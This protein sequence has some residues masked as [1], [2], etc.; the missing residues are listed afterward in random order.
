MSKIN[1]SG[2]LQLTELNKPT[3]VGESITSLNEIYDIPNPYVG[4]RVYVEDE[5]KSYIIKSLKGKIINGILVS[6]AQVDSF[7]LEGEDLRELIQATQQQII[8][9]DNEDISVVNN[10]LKFK[11]RDSSAGLGYVILR[12]DKTFKEQVVAENT[13]Y[14]VRYN[15]NL[16]GEEITMPENSI[17]KFEGGSISNGVITSNIKVI[18]QHNIKCTVRGDIYDTN[19]N[20]VISSFVPSELTVVDSQEKF[21][22]IIEEVKNG[23]PVRAE[24]HKGTYYMSPT[25]FNADFELSGNDGVTIKQRNKRFRKSELVGIDGTHY[26]CSLSEPLSPFSLFVYK[27]RIVDVS[28]YTTQT[29]GVNNTDSEIIPLGEKEYVGVKKGDK[30]KLKAPAGFKIKEGQKI[31]G[32]YDSAWITSKF[33][34]DEMNGE[35]MICTQISNSSV[36]NPNLNITRY[37][38]GIDY[39]LFNTHLETN[40]IYYDESYV[41]IPL[42][43]EYVDV[44]ERKYENVYFP[45]SLI[46]SNKNIKFNN[47]TFADT[48]ALIYFEQQPDTK[49]E[50]HKC[51]VRRIA[52]IAINI[53]SCLEYD[54]PISIIDSCDF[55]DCAFFDNRI[56]RLLGWDSAGF[57]K[58]ADIEPRVKV[59]R[60]FFKQKDCVQYKHTAQAITV[61][62]N[63]EIVDC[64]MCNCT[65]GAMSLSYGNIIVKGC[66]IY[67]D[68]VFNANKRRNY[69][70]DF[71]AIYCN[72]IA[73][74]K[75]SEDSSY[76]YIKNNK[77]HTIL[78]EGC[79]IYG[80]TTAQSTDGHGIY[81]DVGRGDVTCKGNVISA[82]GLHA[83]DSR[84]VQENEGYNLPLSSIR[85]VIEGNVLM[86]PY[87]LVFGNEVDDENKTTPQN[88]YVLRGNTNIVPEKT[89]DIIVDGLEDAGK[90]IVSTSYGLLNKPQF[91][92]LKKVPWIIFKNGSK[93]AVEEE[94]FW[95]FPSEESKYLALTAT[96]PDN[97]RH[98][99]AIKIS[100]LQGIFYDINVE[101]GAT[102]Y[103]ESGPTRN[104]SINIDGGGM[105]LTAVRGQFDEECKSLNMEIYFFNFKGFYTGNIY[106]HISLPEDIDIKYELND[107]D[108]TSAKSVKTILVGNVDQAVFKNV[109]NDAFYNVIKKFYIYIPPTQY[110]YG[111]TR[112]VFSKFGLH[113]INGTSDERPKI[114]NKNTGLDGLVQGFEYFDTTLGKPIWWTGDKWVDSAGE[115]V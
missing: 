12:A 21:D 61:M 33:I 3:R 101:T 41:Y 94:V 103:K 84:W 113:R 19:G 106:G 5:G 26:K 44:V 58:E 104:F 80:Y 22:R 97:K 75:N 32:S 112:Y 96:L 92:A 42:W 9:P 53:A 4:M 85:N 46:K 18:G 14:E 90:F 105:P 83:I 65:A 91:S 99:F 48:A 7:S 64:E 57:R 76:E 27:D 108:T 29:G 28:E 30:F 56:I 79:R 70:R 102:E 47:L 38:T 72:G 110:V 86:S 60:C 59:S 35:Y 93:R 51:N 74:P 23:V 77:Q 17:L 34:V 69:T 100:S 87:R 68:E 36:E 25:T 6:N 88:N 15:F 115:A 63:S 52:D 20:I 31:F 2:S 81:I 67:N 43:C 62:T 55:R 8:N 39:L 95:N 71:G 24:I 50:M 13:I 1:I 49:L 37:N 16:G 111:V 10:V 89:N 78:I 114:N 73:L 98:K 109:D 45:N 66:V 54:T 107:V 40:K 82:V 11:D